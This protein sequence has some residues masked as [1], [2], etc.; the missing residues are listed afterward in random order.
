MASTEMEVDGATTET[1]Q[2]EPNVLEEPGSL[3]EENNDE[4]EDVSAIQ[5]TSKVLDSKTAVDPKSRIARGTKRTKD[6]DSSHS[7]EKKG[8]IRILSNMNF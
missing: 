5:S 1:G 2:E 3:R 6:A 4:K 8:D 7:A